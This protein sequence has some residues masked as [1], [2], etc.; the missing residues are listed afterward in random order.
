LFDS[1]LSCA[2]IVLTAL[3]FKV[4]FLIALP[5]ISSITDF[6]P[7][8]SAFWIEDT[9]AL[10][11]VGG[12]IYDSALASTIPSVVIYMRPNRGENLMSEGG[13]A[14]WNSYRNALSS[15]ASTISD[16]DFNTVIIFEPEWIYEAMY[17]ANDTT[18]EYYYG[19]L[20]TVSTDWT[21][22]GERFTNVTSVGDTLLAW[23]VE[24]WYHLIGAFVEFAAALPS[25]C[26]IY[27]DAG[28]PY[29]LQ[30]LDGLPLKVLNASLNGKPISIRGVS[31]NVANYYSDDY[32]MEYATD[33]V[34][35]AYD[36]Y[37]V[38]DASRNGGTFSSR[39]A[40]EIDDCRYDPPEMNEG[41]AP[42]WYQN[43]D[44]TSSS[45]KTIYGFDAA[46]WVKTLGESD[47]RMYTSGEYHE[48]LI[49][50]NME[51]SDSCPLIP[52]RDSIS[53]KFIWPSACKCD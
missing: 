47:G 38:I 12:Y 37:Y 44:V 4:P 13:L 35:Q 11:T 2:L 53:G 16:K 6:A 43:S 29:Y 8:S 24:K 42:A 15:L 28:S 18:D 7:A 9:T 5:S 50:H 25:K 48:C 40:E 39:T 31:L 10:A 22:A 21:T 1:F 26:Q 36:W 32:V 27:M 46:L 23:N 30:S 33:S 41:Q 19:I 14:D 45:G 3:L 17:I 49:N 34:Y 52:Y 20:S 51:C